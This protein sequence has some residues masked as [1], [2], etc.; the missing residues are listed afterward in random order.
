MK[1][2]LLRHAGEFIDILRNISV[3]NKIVNGWSRKPNIWNAFNSL[4]SSA[5]KGIKNIKRISSTSEKVSAWWIKCSNMNSA[6][7]R[8]K[9]GKFNSSR[10]WIVWAIS[11]EIVL[12]MLAWWSMGVC[13]PPNKDK[14]WNNAGRI[15]SDKWDYAVLMNSVWCMNVFAKKK[16]WWF[17]ITN[18]FLWLLIPNKRWE[19]WWWNT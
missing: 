8:N 11:Q 12:L 4:I 7:W 15:S 1:N 9:H 16:W 18:V 5:V 13:S 14:Q 3:T 6:A 19:P 10:W 2:M 17:N